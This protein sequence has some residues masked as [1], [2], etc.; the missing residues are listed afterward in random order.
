[1]SCLG[2]GVSAQIIE[3]QDT[4]NR[5]I[6]HIKTGSFSVQDIT[7]LEKLTPTKDLE[8]ATSLG[9]Y[10]AEKNP[11]VTLSGVRMHCLL[12]LCLHTLK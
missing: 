8:M 6:R 11:L 7:E 12:L 1:M 3:H 2:H 4:N 9:L 5:T 10:L